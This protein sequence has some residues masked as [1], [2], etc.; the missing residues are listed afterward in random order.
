MTNTDCKLHALK[1]SKPNIVSIT[2][3]VW[4]ER[5][6][7]FYS[8]IVSLLLGQQGQLRAQRRKVQAGHLFIEVFR[9]QVDLIL[10]SFVLLPICQE[11]QLPQY[12]VGKRARHN[13]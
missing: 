12:L 4:L 9:E 13:E 11:I 2:V 3:G 10:V 8:D 1:I 5:S 6:L 7:W